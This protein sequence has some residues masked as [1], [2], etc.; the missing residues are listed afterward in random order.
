MHS[1]KVRFTDFYQPLIPWVNKLR[2]VVFPNDKKWI[3]EDTE[4]YGRSDKGNS[5]GNPKGPRG[6]D[7]LVVL[8]EIKLHI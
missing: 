3:R 4:L 7:S 1:A 5:C 2:K 6:V 8:M